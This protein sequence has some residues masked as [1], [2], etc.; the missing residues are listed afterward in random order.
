MCSVSSVLH[1]A[2]CVVRICVLRL[3]SSVL[4]AFPVLYLVAALPAVCRK[5]GREREDLVYV[6]RNGETNERSE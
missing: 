1:L 4:L 2:F 5:G 3:A 6:C